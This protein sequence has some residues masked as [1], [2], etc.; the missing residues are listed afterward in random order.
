M[1]VT[2]TQSPHARPWQR[3]LVVALAVVAVAHS[4]VLAFWLAPRSPLRDAVGDRTLATYVNPYF[5]QSWSALAPNAQ[6]ADESFTLRAQVKDD[7][8]GTIT[9]SEW[10]DVTAA[11]DRA[12]RRDVDPARVHAIARRLATNLNGAMFG[13]NPRQRVLVRESYTKEPIERLGD[14]LYSAG[15]DRRAA[16]QSYVAYDTMATRFASMYARARF[17][18]RILKVQYRI[19]RRTVPSGATRAADALQGRDFHWFEFGFRR[20]FAASFEAQT[21][22]DDYVGA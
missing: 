10:I 8:T 3:T 13:L 5:E 19:G 1:S 15:T 18:G 11:E 6:F 2:G 14:R 22:F 9:M 7:A 17:D 16:V 4:V 20:G 12:L 21:A